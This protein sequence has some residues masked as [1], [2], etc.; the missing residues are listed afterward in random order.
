MHDAGRGPPSLVAVPADVRAFENYRWHAS[1]ETYLSAVLQAA[2]AMPVIVPALPGLDAAD[3][4]ERVDGVLVTGSA[5]NVHPE[6]YGAAPTP[7][8]EPFDPDR[9]SLTDALIR[10]A[11]KQGVPIL[12]VCRGLQ[13]MNVAFGGSLATEIQRLPGRMDHRAPVHPEQNKR[14][15]IR[16]PVAVTQGGCLAAIVE[17]PV[18]EV[19]SLHRQ[20][21][22]RLAEGLRVEACAGDG[23]VEAVSVEGAPA[24]AL[25]VQWHPEYWAGSDPASQAIF[26]AF[27]AAC[28]AR[29]NARA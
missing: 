6:R 10:T 5:T 27:G 13:E 23:T 16:H 14:F 4:V 7:D 21:I 19:N 1:P 15:A 9:D 12:A 20:A 8:H 28:R 25:A 11:V 24:F 18:I 17:A 26:A 29:R 3:L 22:D 2:G